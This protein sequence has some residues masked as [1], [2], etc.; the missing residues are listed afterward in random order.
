MWEQAQKS[1]WY[2]ADSLRVQGFIHCSKPDQI[3]SVANSNFCGQEE[4]VL[5]C[6]D[7]DKV[8]SEIRYENCTG[9]SELFPHIYGPLS[10]DAV[11][12][13]SEFQPLSDGMFVLPEGFADNIS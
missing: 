2:E 1:G 7:T 6:I 12:S 10:I 4:L 13:V 11:I 8:A 5:L 3:L 9:D